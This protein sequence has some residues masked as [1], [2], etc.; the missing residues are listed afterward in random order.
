MKKERQLVSLRFAVEEGRLE[1]GVRSREGHQME[2][3]EGLSTGK[4]WQ[5]SKGNSFRRESFHP[6]LLTGRE[7][8]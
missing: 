1:M 4:A 3:F 7:Q 6:G 8:V 5:E 2:M